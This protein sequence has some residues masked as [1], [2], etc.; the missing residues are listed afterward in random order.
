MKPDTRPDIR[1]GA[2]LVAAPDLQDPNFAQSVILLCDHGPEGAMGLIVNRPLPVPLSDILPDEFRLPRNPSTVHQ[3]GP[4]Q[5]DHLLFLHG[6][7]EPGL[8][9]HPICASVYLGGDPEVLKR[10]LAAAKAPLLLRCY[11]GYAGWAGGQLEAEMAEGAW[12]LKPARAEDVFGRD[13]D[14]LWRR[15]LTGQAGSRID[16]WV[17][18]GGLELN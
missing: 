8:D 4:V 14:S 7:G 5:A 9:A 11:L 10:A 1:K 3:G 18:P 17:P 6:I 13:T 16:A 2:F 15:L 12:V